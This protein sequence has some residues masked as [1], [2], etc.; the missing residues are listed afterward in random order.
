MDSVTV[1]WRTSPGVGGSVRLGPVKPGLT[2]VH[3]V[4]SDLL[5]WELVRDSATRCR[6]SV[7]VDNELVAL[8][9]LAAAS[10]GRTVAQ[11]V[12]HWARIGRELERSPETSLVNVAEALQGRRDYDVLPSHE[13]AIIRVCWV[14]RMR[15]LREHLRLDLEL[16]SAGR[17]DAE[18]DAGGVVVVREGRARGQEPGPPTR[19]SRRRSAKR[20]VRRARTSRGSR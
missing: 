9:R 16:A 4:A 17:T 14:E 3:P 11:Q 10:N 5:Q 1:L 6:Q 13:Q 2:G 20:S 15:S 7:R 19:P 8:A 12:A 18:L